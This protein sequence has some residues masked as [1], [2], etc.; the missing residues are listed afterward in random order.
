MYIM[1]ACHIDDAGRRR[2]AFLDDP[3]LFKLRPAPTPLWTRQNRNLAH[4]CSFACKSISKLSQPRLPTGR[5]SSPEGYEYDEDGVQSFIIKTVEGPMHQC[6]DE[7]ENAFASWVNMNT[8]IAKENI[9]KL[10]KSLLAA[11]CIQIRRVA[12]QYGFTK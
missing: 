7:S 12:K 4:V 5:R 1:P 11:H 10:P 6:I 3:K 9:E 8:A 2:L